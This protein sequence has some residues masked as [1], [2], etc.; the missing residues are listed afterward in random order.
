MNDALNM[1]RVSNE[2]VNFK[3]EKK[4]NDFLSFSWRFVRLCWVFS[5]LFW[6]ELVC[7]CC[8]CWMVIH[9]DEAHENLF[10]WHYFSS[11]ECWAKK[12]RE[13]LLYHGCLSVW[14]QRLFNGA[15]ERE[16][17]TQTFFVPSTKDV[18][19]NVKRNT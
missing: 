18:N 7:L 19:A 12:K 13:C 4:R 5:P 1:S 17:N 2:F 14:W 6:L 8:V 3:H 10:S 15:F 9:N 16:K 11:D